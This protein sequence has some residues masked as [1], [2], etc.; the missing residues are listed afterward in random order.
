MTKPSLLKNSC[1]STAGEKG[2]HAF[3]KG[4]IPKANIITQQEFELVSYEVAE[5]YVSHYTIGDF[6]PRYPP[7]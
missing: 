4:I 5:Q 3:L 2:V 7:F 6:T 1:G